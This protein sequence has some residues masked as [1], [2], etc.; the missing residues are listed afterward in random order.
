[1]PAIVRKDQGWQL[2]STPLDIPV[3]K[4]AIF[5]SLKPSLNH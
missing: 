5:F 1:M 3:E 2:A 4:S